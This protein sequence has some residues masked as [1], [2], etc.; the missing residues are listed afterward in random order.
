MVGLG[1][2]FNMQL[3]KISNLVPLLQNPRVRDEVRAYIHS[4]APERDHFLKLIAPYRTFTDVGGDDQDI[5]DAPN[6]VEHLALAFRKENGLVGR[7]Y[8]QTY[9]LVNVDK[10]D[11]EILGDALTEFIT[12]HAPNKI[13]NYGLEYS[14][15]SYL[16]FSENFQ[17]PSPVFHEEL[18]KI[19][20][21]IALSLYKSTGKTKWLLTRY[22]N[23]LRRIGRVNAKNRLF[24]PQHD[25]LIQDHFLAAK[26]SLTETL[27]QSLFL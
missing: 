14:V 23:V 22:N 12:W 26:M 10:T 5:L 2:F 27:R 6:T 21:A 17:I 8:N 19:L 20:E 25:G 15:F 13:D 11:K 18:N 16:P 9:N 4:Q 1:Y 7:G 3:H 24:S